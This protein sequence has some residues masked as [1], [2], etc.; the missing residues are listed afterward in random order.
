V[1]RQAHRL[2]VFSWSLDRAAFA[3]YLL[4]AVAPLVALAVVLERWALPALADGVPRLALVGLVL[5]IGVL[6]AASFLMLRRVTWR[7]VTTMRRD[8]E[9]LAALLDAAGRLAEAPGPAEAGAAAVAAALRMAEARGACL[10]DAAPGQPPKLL[11]ATG[12][13]GLFD[14][15]GA[16]VA[17]LATQASRDQRPALLGGRGGRTSAVAIPMAGV[18]V[19]AVAAAE[20]RALTTADVGSLTTLATL[21]S[22][23]A[24]RAQLAH[25]QRNF[26]VHVTDMLVAALDAHL[27]L[28]S[29]HSRRVA[30][31]ANRLGRSLALDDEQR[32]RLHFAALLHDV[33]MLRIPPQRL[34]DP[35][36]HRQHPGL[37][38]RM[39]APIQLW[40]EIAPL[41][42]HHHEWFDGQ[43][44]PDGIAG[45]AIPIESRIIALCE[46]FDS[47]TSASSYKPAVEREEAVRR[48]EA[49]SGSQFDPRVVAAFQALLA[50]NEL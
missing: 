27:D 6:S 50:S 35:K 34:E 49:G 4:G 22:V 11:S 33:G 26:F 41:V 8:N 48:I 42:L 47:M 43:G 20:G 10:L 44:Y 19:L 21:A 9:R 1:T 24:R 25:A 36:A 5:S 3:A 38:H 2:S 40:G 13:A 39:L 18:G 45:E 16:P 30:E 14:R 37:G 32:Q 15:L 17:A 12:E 7:T 29:G 46:A 23:A 28:Q 31:L